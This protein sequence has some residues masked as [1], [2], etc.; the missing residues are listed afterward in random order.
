MPAARVCASV[1]NP[2]GEP[3]P[4]EASGAHEVKA[5][6]LRDHDVRADPILSGM[7]AAYDVDIDQCAHCGLVLGEDQFLLTYCGDCGFEYCR[8]HAEPED[9]ECSITSDEPSAGEE[10][11]CTVTE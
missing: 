4:L 10:A 6:C 3:S 5:I 1:E 2:W 7:N 9:H 8:E 11:D